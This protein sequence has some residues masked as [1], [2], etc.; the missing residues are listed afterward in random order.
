MDDRVAVGENTIER[1]PDKKWV[2]DSAQDAESYAIQNDIS[3][4]STVFVGLE[5]VGV[6]PL[7]VWASDLGIDEFLVDEDG[8]K[9][10]SP[11]HWKAIEPYPVVNQLPFLKRDGW[12]SENFEIEEAW[13]HFL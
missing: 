11:S 4:Q 13:R 12:V 1:F 3:H 9:S 10:R 5:M 6:M 2:C 7:G 8:L